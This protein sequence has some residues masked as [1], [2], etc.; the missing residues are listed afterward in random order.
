MNAQRLMP[1]EASSR[2]DGDGLRTDLAGGLHEAEQGVE[3]HRALEVVHANA[4]V[5]EARDGD[6][7]GLRLCHSAFR[8]SK[9]SAASRGALKAFAVSKDVFAAP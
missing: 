2:T 3:A 6:G 7:S 8:S 9:A 1:S 4:D 5:G